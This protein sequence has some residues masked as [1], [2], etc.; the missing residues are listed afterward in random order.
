[1]K[2]FIFSKVASLQACPNP[3]FSTPVG[4]SASIQSNQKGKL[5]L[6]NSQVV[7]NWISNNQKPVKQW[8]QNRVVEILRFTE[9]SEWMFASSQDMIAD[10]E[11]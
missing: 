5:K 7:L 9:P 4:N 1:M 3:M 8:V 11:M 6:T 10:L 2:K